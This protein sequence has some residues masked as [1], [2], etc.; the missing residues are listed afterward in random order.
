[1][2][3]VFLRILIADSITPLFFKSNLS[4]RGINFFFIFFAS[5]VISCIPLRQRIS[6]AFWLMYPLSPIS[7]PNKLFVNVSMTSIFRSDT[8]PGVM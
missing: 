6:K 5:F 4:A 7:F 3:K 1:M 2:E 8:F